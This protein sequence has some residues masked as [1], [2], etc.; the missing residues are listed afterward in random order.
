LTRSDIP[1]VPMM[2]SGILP[3][4]PG[5]EGF[6]EVFGSPGYLRSHTLSCLLPPLVGGGSDVDRGAD[7]WGLVR[8][9]RQAR[10]D[11]FSY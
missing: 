4:V 5:T 1:R 11:D 2:H 7:Y 3:I 10:R 6:Y 9:V 8:V